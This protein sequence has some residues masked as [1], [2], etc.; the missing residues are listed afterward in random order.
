MEG[1]GGQQSSPPGQLLSVTHSVVLGKKR[2]G[3]RLVAS[4]EMWWIT[5]PISKATL[6]QGHPSL[7]PQMGCPDVRIVLRNGCCQSQ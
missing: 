5:S 2:L 3:R 1:G 4:A 6:G 7:V